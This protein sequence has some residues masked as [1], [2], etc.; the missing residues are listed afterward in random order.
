MNLFFLG[1][2]RIVPQTF[3]R[4]LFCLVNSLFGIPIYALFLKYTGDHVINL[5]RQLIVFFETKFFKKDSDY[6]KNMNI[7]ILISAL[8]TMTAVIFIVALG[9]FTFKWMY[10]EG[11]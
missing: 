10:F 8:L 7:G 6:I 5:L 4:R 9:C 1:K 2:G 3:G 11:M